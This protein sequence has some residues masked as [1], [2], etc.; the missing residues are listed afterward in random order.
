MTPP[1]NMDADE[2]CLWLKEQ[3]ALE[4]DAVFGGFNGFL[5]LYSGPIKAFREALATLLGRPVKG[6]KSNFDRGRKQAAFFGTDI[7]DETHIGRWL[8]D[9]DLD[10]YFLGTYSADPDQIRCATY[11]V[12]ATVSEELIRRAFGKA[13]TAV[14]G[15]DPA[16]VFRRHELP[17]I[18]KDTKLNTVN[19]LPVQL[20]KDFSKMG[21]V[22]A[23]RQICK[24]ELLSLRYQARLE[25][26]PVK[27]ATL[28][29][30]WRERWNLYK[31]HLGRCR[32][33]RKPPSPKRTAA[34]RNRRKRMRARYDFEAIKT[35]IIADSTHVPF[36]L[37]AVPA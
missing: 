6:V 16:R 33:G 5:V 22:E 21:M 14:C 34:L 1:P 23:Y 8:I 3:I 15:A 37:S 30:E 19:S 13:R 26:D 35:S 17:Q 31:Q 7:L 28:R 25:T 12:W 11:R 29:E 24:F 9:F 10:D 4:G 36:V 2:F 20:V 18:I 32:K 27:A